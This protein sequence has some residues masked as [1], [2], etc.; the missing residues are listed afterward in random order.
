MA[1]RFT[2]YWRDPEFRAA[3]D[4]EFEYADRE[5]RL[6]SWITYAIHDPTRPDPSGK[7]DSLIIYVGQSKEFAKRVRKRMRDAG[8]AV[9]RP[10]RQI[11][12]ALYDV[13]A[14]GRVPQFRVLERVGD[15]VA[16]FVSETNWAKRLKAEGYPLLNKWTEQKFGGLPITRSTVPHEWLWRLAVE[17]AIEAGLDIIIMNKDTG[18]DLVLDLADI[19]PKTLLRD[20]KAGALEQLRGLGHSGSVRL[21]VRPD[22]G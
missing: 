4:F 21:Y 16:S 5:G 10:L 14:R 2:Q 6:A 12:G 7:R 19:P 11:D 17:D 9:R 13:M 8:T 20:V 3:V 22:D 1:K 18:Q 15:A